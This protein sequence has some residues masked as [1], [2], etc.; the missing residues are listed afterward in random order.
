L[1]GGVAVRDFLIVMGAVMLVAFIGFAYAWFALPS[2]RDR[3]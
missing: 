2:P 3:K 1:K